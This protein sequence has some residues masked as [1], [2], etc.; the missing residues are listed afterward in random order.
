MRANNS[1]IQ[2]ITEQ[3]LLLE[4]EMRNLEHKMQ[5]HG[6]EIEEKAQMNAKLESQ[7]ALLNDDVNK[8]SE[9]CN[10]LENEIEQM[11]ANV[12]SNQENGD[13]VNTA[14]QEIASKLEAIKIK[15]DEMFEK[16][17]GIRTWLNENDPSRG[18]QY[19][20]QD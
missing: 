3:K 13:L 18:Q 7:Q 17:R 8:L 4:S 15:K 14:L 1:E 2:A 20:M 16:Q 19:H 11:K 5:S 10:S 12:R 9:E 6:E